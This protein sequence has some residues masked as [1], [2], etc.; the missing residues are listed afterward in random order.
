MIHDDVPGVLLVQEAGGEIVSFEGIEYTYETL[1]FVAA[2]S[3]VAAIV[4]DNH[5][6]IQQIISR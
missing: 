6:E 3:N 4:R 5:E 1:S 2:T